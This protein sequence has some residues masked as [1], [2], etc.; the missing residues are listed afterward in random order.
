[1]TG[2]RKR[3]IA[4]VVFAGLVGW[5]F[6]LFNRFNYLTAKIAILRDAPV[7]V[8]IGEPEPC[9]ERCIEIR[10]KYGFT[11]KNFGT[12]VTGSQL[13]GIKDYNYEIKNYMIRKNGEDWAQK[14]ENEVKILTHD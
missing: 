7:I 2:R 10:E 8:T 14:Y 13:R 6:G 9:N 5:Q 1:M 12:K 4:I 11:V 3:N